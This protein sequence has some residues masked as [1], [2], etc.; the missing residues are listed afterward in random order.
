[1][2]NI[3]V[4][5]ATV[6]TAAGATASMGPASVTQGSMAASV[7]LV[8]STTS[9]LREREHL[10]CVSH[11]TGSTVVASV[12]GWACSYISA[13]VLYHYCVGLQVSGALTLDW[14]D[15]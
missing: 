1:M 5:N 8:S 14:C 3:V 9:V 10:L 4:R 7:T 13:G 12:D 15:S 6:L 2:A 11:C